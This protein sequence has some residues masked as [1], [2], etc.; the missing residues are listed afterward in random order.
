[1]IEFLQ[2]DDQLLRLPPGDGVAVDIGAD[3]A[4]YMGAIRDFDGNDLGGVDSWLRIG[5]ADV[6]GD[7]DLDQILVN[8]EI[9]RW[10]EVGLASDGLVHF[11][12][13]GWAGETRVVGIY[14]DPLVEAGVVEAGGEFDSQRR[15]LN[16]LYIE[17][18]NRVLGAD[19]YDGDGLQEV[20]FALTDGTAYLHAYMHA[21]GNIHYANYQVEQQVID[22]LS[23]NGYGEET[24]AGWFPV[25]SAAAPAQQMDV[26]TV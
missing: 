10:A 24:W 1:K 25:A 15:F 26:L 7:G 17:N 14:I 20:Y 6:N 12:D 2:F 5:E 16:D 9:G 23:S 13:H 22:Y 18:I 11:D 3:P 21:D 19:D 8:M 4:T